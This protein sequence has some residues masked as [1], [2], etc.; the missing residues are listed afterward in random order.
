MGR[1][2]VQL[3]DTRP[4]IRNTRELIRWIAERL[5]EAMRQQPAKEKPTSPKQA[6]IVPGV[7]LVPRKKRGKK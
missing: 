6:E 5:P 2:R 7:T 3:S 1:I 4:D